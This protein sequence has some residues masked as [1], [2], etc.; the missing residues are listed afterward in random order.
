MSKGMSSGLFEEKFK[1]WNKK[2]LDLSKRNRL[3]NYKQRKTGTFKIDGN[4]ECLFDTLVN[5]DGFF[6]DVTPNL[7]LDEEQNQFIKDRT[8]K[9]EYIRKQ[10]KSAEDEMGFNIGYAAFGLLQWAE[11]DSF[12]KQLESPLILVPIRIQRENLSSPIVVS[13]KEDE[14]ISINPVIIKKVLD[15]FGV[16]I[17]ENFTFSSI[18]E[19]FLYVEAIIKKLGWTIS[20]TVII[21]TFNFQNLVIQKDLEANKENIH[22][23]PFIKA[24]A[25][26]IDAEVEKLFDEYNKEIDLKNEDSRERLQILDAD[27]SQQEA[28]SRARRGDSFVLQGPPGTGKSQT[29]SN[30]IAEQLGMGRKVLFVSEKQAALEVVYHKLQQKGL[31]EFIL[32]LHNTKQ[33]KG[34]IR[35]Q[36]Q[37]SLQLSEQLYRFKDENLSIYNNL[38]NEANQLNEYDG[39]V[40]DENNSVKK[41]FYFLHGKLANVLEEQDLLFDVDNSTLKLTYDSMTQLF[42]KVDEL[43]KSYISDTFRHKENGWKEFRGDPT[44]TKITSISELFTK[45]S[46]TIVGNEELEKDIQTI[47][48]NKFSDEDIQV[49]IE[50]FRDLILKKDGYF[51]SKWISLNLPE[52]ISELEKVLS[53]HKKKKGLKKSISDNEHRVKDIFE[54]EFLNT[55]NVDQLVKVLKYE[56]KSMFKRLFSSEYK[57]IFTRNKRL[58]KEL[59]LSYEQLISNV[60]KLSVIKN[61]KSEVDILNAEILLLERNLAKKLGTSDEIDS[62]LL[63]QWLKWNNWLLEIKRVIF[64][65]GW[66]VPLEKV[67]MIIDGSISIDWISL[68]ELVKERLEN[69]K[70]LLKLKDVFSDDFP[71]IKKDQKSILAF[72]DNL[73]FNLREEFFTHK[74]IKQELL[75]SYGLNDFVSKLE[76]TAI[77]SS[78][79]LP[80]FLK[81]YILLVLEN[82][83]NYSK[84]S[85]LST[86]ELSTRIAKFK[87]EDKNT[88]SLARDRIFKELVDRLPSVNENVKV[89]GGE[90]SILKKEIAK[91]SR[92]MP[93]RKLIQ[94]LPTLLPRLKPCIMMSPITVSTYFASNKEWEFDLV[95]FDE[96]SQVKPEYAV[97]AISRGKQIIVAGDSKQMPPT[98]FFDSSSENDELSEDEVDV[99]DLES[100]LDELSVKIPETYLNWHYRSKDESLITFS[101]H[102]FYNNRLYTFPTDNS[103]VH[104]NVKFTYVQNGLWESKSG[105]SI[106]AAE[107]AKAVMDI[108]SNC[109]NKS[110]GV[111]AFG[112]SQA[113]IIEEKIL[114]LREEHPELESFFD[115][116]SPEPFF[117]K[118]LENV[119]GDERDVII[120]SIGYGKGPNGKIR[121]NFGPLTQ[122]GGERRLNVAV[123]RARE[124]MNV[125]SSMKGTDISVEGTTNENRLMFRDFLEFAEKGVGALIGYDLFDEESITEFDS[126]FEENVYDYLKNKGY[127][128]HTQVGSSGYR[129]DMAVVH[130]KIPG[131]YVLA[132]EC[133]GAAYHSSRTARDRDRLRQEILESKG[134]NFYRVWSTTWIHDNTNEKNNLINAIEQ[135]IENYSDLDEP[136]LASNSVEEEVSNLI[137]VSA[138]EEES[139][140]PFFY[141]DVYDFKANIT[142]LSDIIMIVAK[143]YVGY[144]TIDLMRHINKE[145][146]D[147]TRLTQGY[148]CVYMQAFDYLVKEG[149]VDVS[150]DL[151]QSVD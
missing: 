2:L 123:S 59:K 97:A 98:S 101:N 57:D 42:Q 30:I 77:P 37:S 78:K 96:A 47:L 29:I 100:I 25:E 32:T 68:M 14:E 103:D 146:F 94:N 144:K 112:M 66:Y 133:D 20:E 6:Y 138:F 107:V 27:S 5:G 102:K 114:Q 122:T 90:I 148:K 1:L 109:P 16:S 81:R 129:I 111:V 23:N 75:G 15:D 86:K 150:G 127:N 70:N 134:W 19:V 11:D 61:E 128:V 48:S 145:V 99:Q 115:E 149:K 80:I 118:N 65:D 35:N 105:N 137:M 79:V 95:I 63:V 33:K 87:R 126:D 24:L 76:K 17:D 83:P 22:A 31:S 151:I 92:L 130:P 39:I 67:E 46:K 38:N 7:S 53:K 34:D 10:V 142:G 104:S 93:T 120:L 9:L 18:S 4:V 45:I 124:T 140:L 117:V 88:F 136:E 72:I 82:S 69:K 147:K 3:L 51:P 41:S 58:T 113:R 43:G 55:E 141:G 50:Q 143:K 62:D 71:N 84:I 54:D 89:T 85:T 64:R 36:L 28:I 21:D 91:K 40:H 26:E 119:Q 106:E 121:M 13:L 135:A 60:E 44:Y 139:A 49:S 116:N 131:R 108:A 74:R 56:Y 8:R 12:G 110:L 132:V 52:V 73:D 125:I